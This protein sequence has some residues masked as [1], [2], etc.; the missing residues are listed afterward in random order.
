M[1][2]GIDLGCNGVYLSFVT[3]LL[4]EDD[5]YT[6]PWGEQRKFYRI[7]T[8]SKLV[9]CWYSP[10][11]R[12]KTALD[13]AWSIALETYTAGAPDTIKL[14]MTC[15]VNTKSYMF[16]LLVVWKV[17]FGEAVLVRAILLGRSISWGFSAPEFP[18]RRLDT[19][20]GRGLPIFFWG[21]W[22]EQLCSSPKNW[23]FE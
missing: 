1:K 23:Y 3:I 10:R 22:L 7:L 21:S 2:N 14:L 6:L 5:A 18:R 15:V 4:S 17:G 16:R 12:V 13:N 9:W 20:H 11:G 19:Y 8:S